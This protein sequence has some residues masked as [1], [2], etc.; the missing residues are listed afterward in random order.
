MSAD[1]ECKDLITVSDVSEFVAAVRDLRR[2]WGFDGAN[3]EEDPCGPWFRGHRQAQWQPRPRLYRD[4]LCNEKKRRRI[5]DEIREEFMTRAPSLCD[6]KP[7]DPDDWEWYFLMQHHGAPT[8]LL[9]W[10]DGALIALYF[11]VKDNPGSSPAA[12]WALDPY[13]LNR[14]VIGREEVLAPSAAGIPDDDRMLVK[15]WLPKRFD[16]KVRLRQE[17]IAVFPTHIATRIRSQ[18]SCF[19]IHGQDEAG[20]ERFRKGR[21]I[22]LKKILIPSRRVRDIKR[23]LETCGIDEST[24]FP[25]LDGLGRCV[26]AKWTP[27]R[28]T[29]PHIG[30]YTRLGCSKVDKNGVGV[31]AI[32]GIKKDAL[33]FR[34]DNEEFLWVEKASFGG[35]PRAIRRLYDDFA[36]LDESQYCCPLNFNR[37]TVSWYL[38]EPAEGNE[39]NVRCEKGEEQYEFY[40]LRAIKAGEELTVVYDT[41]SDLPPKAAH[42]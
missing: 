35:Q 32:R 37:L 11:V 25:D 27:Q 30:V 9:D 5:E 19:T 31:F 23:D 40:A 28:A 14:Q 10:T 17:P 2:R 15:L 24:I 1:R 16:A 7:A 18:R 12:V 3:G 6:I 22:C 38:N 13:E 20:L 39:P 4:L 8:R 42:A 21:K 29:S 36:V 41:Y 34:G 33:L 26:S